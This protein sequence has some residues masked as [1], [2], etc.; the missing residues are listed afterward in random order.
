MS[1]GIARRRAVDHLVRTGT[2]APDALDPTD[3]TISYEPDIE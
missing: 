2:V 3:V 1:E